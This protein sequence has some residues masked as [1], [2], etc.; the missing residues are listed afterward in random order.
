MLLSQF[1]KIN[2]AKLI[3]GNLDEE[4]PDFSHDT[5]QLKKGQLYWI[6]KGNHFDGHQF[7]QKALELGACG[8]VGSD[9]A[10]LKKFTSQTNLLLC[11]ND[12]L[13][14][15]Q[16]FAHHYR[17]QFNLPLIAITGSNGKTSTKEML[18]WILKSKGP[19]LKTKG[20]LNNLIGVPLTLKNLKA[21]H[22]FAV[23]EM[24]MNQLQEIKTLTQIASPTHALITNI[25]KAHL[26]NLKSLKGVQKAKGE[27]F[28]N[29][30]QSAIAFY[31]QNDPLVAELKTPAQ[32]ITMQIVDE[33]KPN[34]ADY[35]MQVLN[36]AQKNT[37]SVLVLN[38]QKK[39]EFTL[40]FL[41]SHQISNWFFCYCIAHQ[42]GLSDDFIQTQTLSFEIP[43]GRGQAVFLQDQ[44]ILLDDAYN[45]NLDSTIQALENL[46]KRYPQNRKIFCFGQ[47]E[48]LGE[49][50]D[51]HHTQ[52]GQKALQSGVD[53]LFGIGL[54]TKK[55]IASF[56]IAE[57]NKTKTYF[58]E[59]VDSVFEVLKNILKPQD[60]VLIK[61]SRSSKLDVLVR[62]LKAHF[63]K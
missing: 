27:L 49:F 7:I 28:E 14:A 34:G 22:Q 56:S 51:D 10:I 5:R 59:K 46:A 54:Q 48:E 57:K 42:L 24:G 32:K 4:F 43:S 16:N 11:V 15:L 50:S 39:K 19:T 13:K 40:P 18:A 35:Q 29:I 30:N 1:I 20:N 45:A 55:S 44:M 38:H 9:E 61:G 33:L 52:V 58:F 31:N 6:L 62:Q 2:Q 17:K 23:V 47:M 41:A 8:I 60:V 25:Q 12:S 36:S 21:K 63:Q 37:T 3:K 53:F 26:E